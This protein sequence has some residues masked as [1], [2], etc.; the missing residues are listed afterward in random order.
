MR[1]LKIACAN[2]RKALKWRNIRITWPE[3]CDRLRKTTYTSETVDEYRA[4]GKDE[5]DA[6]KD[7]GSFVGGFLKDGR[8]K[9]VNVECRSLI[10][11]DVDSPE[12]D[13]QER[14]L[15]ECRYAAVLYSTHSHTP[16]RPRYRVVIALAEDI[17]P[18]R[19][20]AV[21]RYLAAEFGIEQYD[22]VSFVTNQLMHWP[23]TPRDGDYVYEVIDKPFLNADEYLAAHPGWQD[24]SDLPV[25]KREQNNRSPGG[26]EQEDPLTKEGIVGTFCR[27]YSIQDAISKFLSGVY[28]PSAVEGRYDYIPGEGSCGV[29][30]YDDKFAFS[31]HATDPAGGRLSNA[32]DL[33]RWHRFGDEDEK[34]SFLKM[35]G[36]AAADPLVKVM[37]EKEK[38]AEAEREFEQAV[39]DWEEPI[40]FGRYDLEPFPVEALPP[41][42]GRYVEAVAES[43]QTPID[44]AGTA[45][46]T[47]ISVCTQGKYVIK[48][49]ADW[50]EPLNTFSNIIASPSER[51]SAVL[52][53]V[54]SPLDNYEV[55]YNIRNAASVEGSRMR[56]RILERRQKAIEDKVAKGNAEPGELEQIAKEIAEFVEETPLHLYV[57]DITTEKLVSVMAGNH[58]RAALISSEGGI[59]DTLA[60]IY[61]KNVNIDVMLKGYSGDTIRVDRIG[62]ESESIMDPSLTILLMT[63]P[64]VISDVLSNATFRG[65]GLTARFLYCLPT[66]AVGGRRFQSRPVPD[67]IYQ[68]YEQK[69]VDLL[70]DAYPPR[71]EIITLSGE[72]SELLTDFA[73][74][75][76][77][78]LKKEYAEI[79]D[80]VGKLVGNTLRIAGLL[81][82]AGIYRAPE[83]LMD[84]EP[85]TVSGE[86]MEKAIRLGRYY[87]SHAL[88]VY[89]VIPEATM[90]KQADRIL[91]MIK[92]KELSEFDRRTAMRYCR[93]FKTVSEIQP[94]LDFL[95]D[96]GYIVRQPERP[97]ANGRPPLPKYTV[98]PSVLSQV[99][100]REKSAP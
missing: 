57:D 73:E 38:L 23:S 39:S 89:D 46:L 20:A 28:A 33:V 9:A 99:P 6:A 44:M 93:T 16:D 98:N 77:P 41:D 37:L 53:A 4:M 47:L 51:K 50:T 60:G 95:D 29:V 30:V 5:R 17:P 43:T 65:R 63:Q 80:W 21:S 67:E 74:E 13:F 15:N 52:H 58:G 49:K 85:L 42:I 7:R 68:R 72:A 88:A 18:E 94:V 19:Y 54:A 82:R 32:F 2:S 31:H 45:V 26:K 81:C 92:E 25:S 78:K 64:K 11:H 35:C 8:R 75:I 22:P 12:P 3:L 36:F 90:H 24:H 59:F 86:T 79:A 40:P 10:T 61:T 83:F 69:M 70:E 1:E 84:K 76:E 91:Q 71:P 66:S 55:Q 96:Y 97:S 100:H 27:T 87:L 48:G 34:T 56:K 62:R 14:F